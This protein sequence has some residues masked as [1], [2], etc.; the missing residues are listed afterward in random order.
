MMRPGELFEAMLSRKPVYTVSGCDIV[1]NFISAMSGTNAPT[2]TVLLFDRTKTDL[3]KTEFFATKREA[4]K[5]L[6]NA[7]SRVSRKLSENFL[8]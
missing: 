2:V 8:N 6:K 4:R 7:L 5:K 1:I 3:F